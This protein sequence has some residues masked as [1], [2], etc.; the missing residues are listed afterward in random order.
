MMDGWAQPNLELQRRIALRRE[1]RGECPGCGQKLFKSHGSGVGGGLL[2]FGRRKKNLGGTGNDTNNDAGAVN[3]TR[4]PVTI[5]GKA[6]NGRCL[7][8]FPLPVT[9]TSTSSPSPVA[10]LDANAAAAPGRV[11]NR[12][13][14]AATASMPSRTTT[15]IRSVAAAHPAHPAHP[16]AGAAVATASATAATAAENT[17]RTKQQRLQN[18]ARHHQ[19]QRIHD[20]V[21]IRELVYLETT[22]PSTV[23]PAPGS[24]VRIQSNVSNITCDI[25]TEHQ[26]DLVFVSNHPIDNDD[27]NDDDGGGGGVVPWGERDGQ[28]GNEEKLLL[29]ADDMERFTG[30]KVS[31]SSSR[32]ALVGAATDLATP[33]PPQPSNSN[34]ATSPASSSLAKKY[35]GDSDDEAR[36]VL[37]LRRNKG[38]AAAAT[39]GDAEEVGT[40]EAVSPR[41]FY[42]HRHENIVQ[43]QQILLQRLHQ[44]PPVSTPE[45][46]DGEDGNE[47]GRDGRRNRSGYTSSSEES[48]HEIEELEVKDFENLWRDGEY[49]CKDEHRDNGSDQEQGEG[50]D[51]SDR[52]SRMF[53]TPWENGEDYERAAVEQLGRRR[54]RSIQNDNSLSSFGVAAVASSSASSC[55]DETYSLEPHTSLLESS[56]GDSGRNDSTSYPRNYTIPSSHGTSVHRRPDGG[57]M[58]NNDNTEIQQPPFRKAAFSAPL[59]PDDFH[60]DAARSLT[61]LEEALVVSDNA[62]RNEQ[63]IIDVNP[64]DDDARLR[65]DANPDNE[66][67][68]FEQVHGILQELKNDSS[69]RE[70]R[71]SAMDNFTSMLWRYKES[72]VSAKNLFVELNGFDAVVKI[73]WADID[74]DVIGAAGAEIA[75]ALSLVFALAASCADRQKSDGNS[76]FSGPQSEECVDALLI[77]MQSLEENETVQE[78]GCR[79]LCCL[80]AISSDN[81]DVTDGSLSGAVQAVLN[82]LD[83]HRNA[84][85]PDNSSYLAVFEWS[86]R[87]LYNQCVLSRHAEANMR[88]LA[89]AVVRSGKTGPEVLRSALVA[90]QDDPVLVGRL[91]KLFW[92]LT[93][94]EDVAQMMSSVAH[95]VVR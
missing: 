5:A 33:P 93:A 43:Q 28:V 70:M 32:E 14:A 55:F 1:K 25:A 38:G 45:E 36:P 12:D 58:P 39:G 91:C 88:A 56:E 3:N 90:S 51:E 66:V 59:T 72:A 27:D 84:P 20:D 63:L 31:S 30:L 42:Q 6:L 67:N 34:S 81:N 35:A 76:V 11:H 65:K 16:Q 80:S 86:I 10:S 19:Q 62:L 75:S 9:S 17:H 8:C 29:S 26:H 7:V 73:L 44:Q 41:H 89:R 23:P 82:A 2:H 15:G 61:S 64:S 22:N 48:K 24:L 92:C 83:K 40:A 54:G 4:I 46:Q 95:D 69:D 60:S 49:F 50:D 53:Q 87:A 85:L 57:E 74:G 77:S 78:L 71:V 52:P 79:I 21:P 94:S 68:F 13:V 18:Q 47:E 37:P